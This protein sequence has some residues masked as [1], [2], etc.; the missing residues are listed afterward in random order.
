MSAVASR[1]KR[2]YSGSPGNERVTVGRSAMAPM[3]RSP[4]FALPPT[5]GTIRRRLGPGSSPKGWPANREREV[6]RPRDVPA[7]QS[8]DAYGGKGDRVHLVVPA[9]SRF[10]R[11][12]R[13]V[14]ADAAGR[15][16]CDVEEIEDFRIAVDE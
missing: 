15:A 11:T 3:I 16:G 5:S 2:R 6:R 10:L 14:A 9:S 7:M 1:A 8:R 4:W 13:L 12:T